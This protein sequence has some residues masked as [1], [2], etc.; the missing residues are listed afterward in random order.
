MV[1]TFDMAMP[2]GPAAPAWRVAR[3]RWRVFEALVA[4]EVG[5]LVLDDDAAVAD[6]HDLLAGLED[7][8]EDVRGEDD[9]PVRGEAPDEAEHLVD[10]P[11]IEAV[12][13]LVEDEHLG[14][15]DE[16]LREPD[17]LAVALRQMAEHAVGD[18]PEGAGLDHA[19]ERLVE[20]RAP[21]A[22][23]L[24]REAEVGH[25]AHLVVERRILGEM[26]D[27]AA[28]LGRLLEDVVAGDLHG[29]LGG[30]EVPGDHPHRRR[31]PGP[32]GA[33]EPEDLT[34]DGGE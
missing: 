29:A 23:Q 27:A 9:R 20:R 31:L 24:R 33:E 18:A 1:R 12:R 4:R 6:D 5:E 8:A 13:G 3:R 22:A 26:A 14:V 7:L 17:P 28:H 25:H 21:D 30:G 16:R 2:A 11:R 19:V 32:V 34:R 15:V 10:L